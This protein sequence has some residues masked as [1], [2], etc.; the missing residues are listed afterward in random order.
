M[1]DTGFQVSAENIDRFASLYGR[2]ETGKLIALETP[3]NSP[4]TNGTYFPRGNGGLTSTIT[5]YYR[6][7]KM[8][9]NGGTL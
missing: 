7:V 3:A 5:D 6:F 1:K 9:A 8:L 4:Y 2:D